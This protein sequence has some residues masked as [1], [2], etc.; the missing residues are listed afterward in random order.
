LVTQD[1]GKRE[2]ALQKLSDEN[3]FSAPYGLT[4]VSRTSDQFEPDG[5]W[6]GSSWPQMN[7]LAWRATSA[8]GMSEEADS[9]A[10]GSIR[11]TFSSG[12]SEHW[13]PITGEG[14]GASPQTWATIA[15][16]FPS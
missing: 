3:W 5:Y 2:E 10:K 8:A 9:I 4:F 14:R 13:N 11:G 7:Y 1:P 12:F 15:A 16:A 6:R